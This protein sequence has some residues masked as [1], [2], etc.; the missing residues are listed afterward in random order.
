MSFEK[1]ETWG[2]RH[3]KELSHMAIEPNFFE[4][5]FFALSSCCKFLCRNKEQEEEFKGLSEFAFF[6][7]IQI[8][9]Q[10]VAFFGKPKKQ[11]G[12]VK[13]TVTYMFPFYFYNF[14]FV[15]LPF[16]VGINVVFYVWC[17]VCRFE[18]RDCEY[19]LATWG[20]NHVNKSESRDN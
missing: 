10:T 17:K 3:C 13:L 8:I 2:K 9:H 14:F 20:T 18:I 1:G 15:V 12:M 7:E 11:K 16:G 4:H 5:A 6:L 19:T